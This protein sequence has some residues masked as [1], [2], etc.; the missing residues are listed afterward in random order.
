MKDLKKEIYLRIRDESKEGEEKE[1]LKFMHDEENCRFC[2]SG[3][4]R[5][6]NN[7]EE[8]KEILELKNEVDKLQ[9]NTTTKEDISHF[10]EEKIFNTMETLHTNAIERIKYLSSLGN[11]RY[12]NKRLDDDLPF[13][14]WIIL[15]ESDNSDIKEGEKNPKLIPVEGIVS[16]NFNDEQN[17]AIEK[18]F[19]TSDHKLI[20]SLYDIVHSNAKQQLKK[21]K[22]QSQQKEG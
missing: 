21:S 5:S 10:V 2:T 1:I 18:G 14:A 9:N 22:Q 19:K 16:Y 4:C 8:C 6:S 20:S 3:H 11:V 13:F 15:E 17:Q 7:I 12:A